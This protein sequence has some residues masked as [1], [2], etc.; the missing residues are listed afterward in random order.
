VG[1]VDAE[2]TERS[3][4]HGELAQA[5]DQPFMSLVRASSMLLAMLSDGAL[6]APYGPSLNN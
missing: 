2:G 3:D 1:V 4:T 6:R 5:R